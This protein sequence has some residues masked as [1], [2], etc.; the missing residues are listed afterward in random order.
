[1]K[2]EHFRR[3]GQYAMVAPLDVAPAEASQSVGQ[4]ARHA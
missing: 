1:V 4:A 3:C 2:C